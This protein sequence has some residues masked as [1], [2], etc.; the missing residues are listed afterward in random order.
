LAAVTIAAVAGRDTTIGVLAPEATSG[1]P[2]TSVIVLNWNGIEDTLACLV[3]LR[4]ST[5]AL[6]VIVVDNGSTDD[7]LTRITQSGLADEVL[8]T[9][10]NLG[11]AEGNN[12]G[13]LLALDRGSDVIIV[14]NNDTTVDPDAIGRLVEALGTNDLAA[15]SPDIRYFDTPGDSWF[16]GGVI[17]HG[18]PRHLQ[19][20]ELD[21]VDPGARSSVFST[22][23]ILTGCCLATRRDV[24]ERVG[25]FDSDYFLIFEDSDW[26]VRA[27]RA[28]VR[29]WIVHDSRVFHRVSRSIGTGPASLLA[30]F[31]FLRNGLRFQARYFRRECVRFVWAWLLRPAPRMWRHGLRRPLFFRLLGLGAFG[32]GQAGRAPKWVE[33]LAERLN[34]RT[35][36]AVHGAS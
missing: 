29:M 16:R 5:M 1:I 22:S 20:G 13:V 14:L 7:S 21:A 31:Y 32:L 15:V 11:F 27:T 30:D 2:A 9:G 10:V 33:R 24:W 19:P 12:R 4:A 28:G 23:P 35:R 25:S 26:S 34:R 36:E 18:R 8:A 6:H 17:D 3:S